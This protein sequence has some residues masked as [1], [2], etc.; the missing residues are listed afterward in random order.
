MDMWTR[1]PVASEVTGEK[2]RQ[3]S[4]QWQKRDYLP[5][6]RASSLLCVPFKKKSLLC[7]KV[8]SNTSGFGDLVGW[9]VKFN[10]F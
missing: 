4:I 5:I 10:I 6:G 3:G 8:C 7:V 9:C 2:T 1:T